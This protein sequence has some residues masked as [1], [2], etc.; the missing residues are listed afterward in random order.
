[1]ELTEF[2]LARIAEDEEGARRG[3][4]ERLADFRP[5][6]PYSYDD[7]YSDV[8]MSCGRALAECEAKRRIVELHQG[9]HECVGVKFR[10]RRTVLVAPGYQ[11]ANDPTLA[12]LA[13][14][15]ADHPDYDKSWRP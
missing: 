7:E 4:P 3:M 2:L 11:F 10:A 5:S 13:L 14:P 1:M 12:L 15:Y 9:H 8:T 6:E